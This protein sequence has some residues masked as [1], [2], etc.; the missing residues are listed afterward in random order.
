[1]LEKDMS[2]ESSGHEDGITSCS[3][4]IQTDRHRELS[5]HSR[6]EKRHYQKV[7]SAPTRERES[8]ERLSTRSFDHSQSAS[9][10]AIKRAKLLESKVKSRHRRDLASNIETL[11]DSIEK[12]TCDLRSLREEVKSVKKTQASMRSCRGPACTPKGA[13]T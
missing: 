12:L 10:Q 5:H 11:S 9:R 3:D 7:R 4:P 2:G 8:D 6:P 1:M 13:S